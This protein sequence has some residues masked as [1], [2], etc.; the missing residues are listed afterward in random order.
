MPR[1]Q[2]QIRVIASID[3]C[4]SQPEIVL[5]RFFS[6]QPDIRL[7]T[8]DRRARALGITVGTE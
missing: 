5:S 8:A 7:S 2:M 4:N 3:G 6:G 1:Q